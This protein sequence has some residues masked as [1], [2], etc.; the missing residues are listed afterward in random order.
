MAIDSLPFD[1]VWSGIAIT[2]YSDAIS[3]T[4]D[5]CSFRLFRAVVGL[6][7]ACLPAFTSLFGMLWNVGGQVE[8][9]KMNTMDL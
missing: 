1:P 7:D 3:A 8:A 5:V 9:N 4:S 2:F 6:P